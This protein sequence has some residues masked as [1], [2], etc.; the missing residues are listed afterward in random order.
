MNGSM[1]REKTE[2]KAGNRTLRHKSR[3][4]PRRVGRFN[5]PKKPKTVVETYV[6]AD[7][8]IHVGEADRI[9]KVRRVVSSLKVGDFVKFS[10]NDGK[11]ACFCLG[12]VVPDGTVRLNQLEQKKT[13]TAG[14]SDHG[15]LCRSA[16]GSWAD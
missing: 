6:V 3:S 9:A 10:H 4:L 7:G 5:P 13:L 14:P 1:V 8:P 12:T 11:R 15:Y 2:D 16:R